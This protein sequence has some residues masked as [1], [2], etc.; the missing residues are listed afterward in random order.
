MAAKNHIEF[1]QC[2]GC[3]AQLRSFGIQSPE[4]DAMR[5]WCL[6]CRSIREAMSTFPYV[7]EQ[8]FPDRRGVVIEE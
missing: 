4:T 1:V 7:G 6:A 5:V 8:S 3:G 2:S